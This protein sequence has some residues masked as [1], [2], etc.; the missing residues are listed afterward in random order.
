MLPLESLTIHRFRGL[1]DLELSG[2]GRFNVLVGLNNAGKSS[3]LE[4]VATYACPLRPSEWVEIARRREMLYSRAAILEGLRWLFPH[5]DER[6]GDAGELF[7]GETRVSGTGSFPVRESLARFKELEGF[8]DEPTQDPLPGLPPEGPGT[9]RGAKLALRAVVEGKEPDLFGETRTE[10]T[11]EI[12]LWETSRGPIAKNMTGPSLP[13]ISI[14]PFSHRAQAVV[15][16]FSEALYED[17]K[18]A[19]LALVKIFDA[20][21]EDFEVLKRSRT[22]PAVYVR[23]ARFGRAPLSAFGDGMRRALLMGISLATAR[24][25]ILLVDEI[26]SAIHAEA[27][28]STF[29]WL[30][31]TCRALDVQ[32]FTTTHSLEAIDALLGANEGDDLMVYRLEAR[33]GQIRAKGFRP[34]QLRLLREEL[35]Q[36]VRS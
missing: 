10:L 5:P 9:R 6:A 14:T 26:E 35:G 3:V 31:R 17:L 22:E 33:R 2:L 20:E 36:E 12:D 25:G 21:I 7:Q 23:H 4:A 29:R 13:V 8:F 16:T 18:P 30:Q 34:E 1:R 24:G 32:V 11:F 28:E 27:L 15:E 19:V